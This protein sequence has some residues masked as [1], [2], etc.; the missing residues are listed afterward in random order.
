M[1]R[2]VNGLK[3]FSATKAIDRDRLGEAVTDWMRAHP[4]YVLEDVVITQSSD[5]EFHCLAITVLYFDPKVK[6]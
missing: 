2:K 1:A 6:P 4:D 3:V 5:S